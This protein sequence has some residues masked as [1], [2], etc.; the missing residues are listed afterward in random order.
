MGG[1]NSVDQSREYVRGAISK[2]IQNTVNSRDTSVN[3]STVVNQTIEGV[4]VLQ[5]ANCPAGQGGGSVNL[6]NLSNLKMESVQNLKTMDTME[7]T[8]KVVTDIEDTVNAT[9]KA[10]RRGTEAVGADLEVDQTFKVTNVT[11]Q[12]INSSI[13][14]VIKNVIIQDEK[15]MKTS[16][17]SPWKPPV[18][19]R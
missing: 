12:D 17:Q 3:Q 19:E 6:S 16:D 10:E 5:K 8:R 15:T 18:K 1:K 11:M 7:L 9:V 13:H 4:T 14:N 2:T